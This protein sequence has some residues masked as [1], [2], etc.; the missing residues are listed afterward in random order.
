MSLP[1]PEA[2]RV[3]LGSLQMQ[4]ASQVHIPP[5]I[6]QKAFTSDHFNDVVSS[7]LLRRQLY[8]PSGPNPGPPHFP[9]LE[10]PPPRN[11]HTSPHFPDSIGHLPRNGHTSPVQAASQVYSPPTISQKAYMSENFNDV[12]STTFLG[13]QLYISSSPNLGP[14]HFSDSVGPL[15]RNGKTSIP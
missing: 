1:A 9:D 14:P 4:A 12:V 13:R 3:L 8:T 7:T 15:P 11:E 6:S 2:S 5:T 10:G